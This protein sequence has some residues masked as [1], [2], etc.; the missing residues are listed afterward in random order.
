MTQLVE[1]LLFL[2]R[3]DAQTLDV[4]LT[5]LEL[6]SVVQNVCQLMVPLAEA[7]NVVLAV[8]K[9]ELALPIAGHEAA[10]HRRV[11]LI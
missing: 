3:C 7:K 8:E 4:P 5:P 10:I 11:V 2:A 6:G 1:D 9:P